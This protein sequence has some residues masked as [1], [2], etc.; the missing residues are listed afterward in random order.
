MFIDRVAING[1]DGK[2]VGNG[3][4]RVVLLEAPVK[5]PAG[6]NARLVVGGLTSDPTD[7][8]GIFGNYLHATA[9]TMKRTIIAEGM[10]V[11]ETQDW[12]FRA[13]T[14]EAIEMHITFERGVAQR[15]RPSE[16]KYYSAKTG[17]YIVSQED[18]MTDIMRN[19][20]TT[21]PD[22]VKQFQFKAGGGSYGKLLG[23]PV[24]ML[25]WDN[26]LFDMRTVST[27]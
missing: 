21:P 12:V 4:N 18:R 10:T 7:A 16:T 13:A 25:S 24:K 20:T 19:V 8:P 9:A 15:G 23:G 11:T 17:K 6:A 26:N 5:D 22:R 14:G 3:S 27:P 2:P 1:P